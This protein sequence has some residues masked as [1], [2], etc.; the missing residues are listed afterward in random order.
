M[1]EGANKP[2]A[3]CHPDRAGVDA[4]DGW[5]ESH[6]SYPGRS[7]VLLE[8]ARAVVRRLDGA[9]EVSNGQSNPAEPR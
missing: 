3:Q 2:E 6:A 9:K 8:T 5:S 4:A 7:L 1:G